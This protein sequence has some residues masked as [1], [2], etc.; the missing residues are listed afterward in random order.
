M[1][2]REATHGFVDLLPLFLR[3]LGQLV[4]ALALD[5]LALGAFAFLF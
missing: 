3:Q 4:L 2:E 1:G 5:P